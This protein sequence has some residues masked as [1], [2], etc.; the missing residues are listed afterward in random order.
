LGVAESTVL[1]KLHNEL[2]YVLLQDKWV[3]HEL[4]PEQKQK[5]IEQAAQIKVWLKTGSI[6][7][8][9]IQ[10]NGHQKG[11]PRETQER[12]TRATKKFD[13]IETQYSDIEQHILFHMDNAPAHNARLTKNFL[14]GT[15]LY[16]IPHP[17]YS[18]DI[19]PSDFWAFGDLKNKMKGV[20]FH[21]RAEIERFVEEQCGQQTHAKLQKVL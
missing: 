20:T 8:I 21:D 10:T 18:P 5:R 3:L 13:T 7:R 14:E 2:H 19:A 4:M 6:T 15:S 12:V 16:R 1:D 11:T 9:L 17:P